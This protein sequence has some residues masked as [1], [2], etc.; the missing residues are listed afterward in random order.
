MP[1]P[2]SEVKPPAP[3]PKDVCETCKNWEERLLHEGERHGLCHLEPPHITCFERRQHIAD[4]A[5]H[6][7]SFLATFMHCYHHPIT[8]R[9]DWCSHWEKKGK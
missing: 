1:K 3:E 6:Y 2:D 8:Q 5:T 9:D 7:E 4:E